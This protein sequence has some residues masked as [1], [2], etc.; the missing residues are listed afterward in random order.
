MVNYGRELRMGIDIRRKGKVKKK[1]NRI[2]RKNKEGERRSWSI[3]EEDI[4]GNEAT[5]I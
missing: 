4:G 2:C 5:S 1:N 3:I